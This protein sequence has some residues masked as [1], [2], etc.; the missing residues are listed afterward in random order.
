[1][2]LER[3]MMLTRT[4]RQWPHVRKI[5]G[6]FVA[7]LK[8]SWG[9]GRSEGGGKVEWRE[10]HAGMRCFAKKI[11]LQRLFVTLID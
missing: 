7:T 9:R 4:W 8:S 2:R 3:E 1:M 5:V 6:E 10:E 11:D